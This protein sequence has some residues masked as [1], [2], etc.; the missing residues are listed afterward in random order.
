[1]DRTYWHKQ[2]SKPLFPDIVWSRPENRQ[3]AGKLL[4]VG[5]NLHGFAAPA[6]AYVEA[7]KAGIGTT[8]AILPD[9][10]QKTVGSFLENAYFAPSTPSGSLARAAL[11]DIIEHAAWAD[12]ILVAGDL[13][14]NSETAILLESLLAK[15]KGPVILTKDAVDNFYSY[16]ANILERADTTLVVSL[17]QLQQLASKAKYTYALRYQMDLLQ[18][19]EWLHQF[20]ANYPV[21]IVM[22]HQDFML[23]AYG[24]EVSTTPS[25]LEVWRVATAA[26]TSVWLLQN[27]AKKFEAL[28]TALVV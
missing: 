7:V 5:G 8:R 21:G 9:S 28:T 26:R 24:G 4:I 11:A 16:P 1:M 27:P 15:T 22:Q 12:G 20:T 6:E 3:Q 17:S 10:I 2:T 19:V 13:G 23:A 18:V 14:R 25:D